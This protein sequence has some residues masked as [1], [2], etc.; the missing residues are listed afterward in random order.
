MPKLTLETLGDAAVFRCQGR[1]VAGDEAAILREVVL[2]Q[3]DYRTLILDL[4][5]VDAIDAGGLG[6]LLELQRWACSNA[7]QFKLMS[8]AKTIERVLEVTN[9]DR[10]LEVCSEKEL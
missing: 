1:L 9:L 5:V 6:A 7:I 2:S 10:V 3:A 8:V 4:A